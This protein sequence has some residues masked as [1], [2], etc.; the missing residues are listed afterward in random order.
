MTRPE[1]PLWRAALVLYGATLLAAVVGA[2]G[3]SSSAQ[4]YQQLTLPGFAPPSWVFSPVWTAL[5]LSMATAALLVW[6]SK[7]A[8]RT[9]PVLSLYLIHLVVNALWSWLFFAW[10]TGIGATL[11]VLLLLA[12]VLGLTL[13]FRHYS[14]VAMWLMLP[15]VAWVS[16]ATLLTI[17][18]WRMNPQLL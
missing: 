15:Y 9:R 16:F 18:I 4:F 11:G 14:Q 3:S 13:K 7:M 8:Y 17:S 12:M 2:F 1:T 10:Q 5:Y 6:R